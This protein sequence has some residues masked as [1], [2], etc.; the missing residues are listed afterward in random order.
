MAAISRGVETW[1]PESGH[2]ADILRRSVGA[3]V[4][5]AEEINKVRDR[6]HKLADTVQHHESKLAQ[7][8]I[9]L[10]N[11]AQ[12][13]ESVRGQMSTREQLESA[14]VLFTLRLDKAVSE[15]TLKLLE[16][17]TDLDPIKRGIHWAVGL[18]LTTVILAILALVIKGR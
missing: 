10:A 9:V 2:V 11:L 16:V 5:D 14:V 18:I 15:M 4:S 6:M 13:V 12:T 8:D 7:H 17:H 3:R 1:Q